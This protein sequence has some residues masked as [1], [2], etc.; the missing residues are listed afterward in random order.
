MKISRRGVLLG[1]AAA[2]ALIA[3]NSADAWFKS[4]YAMGWQTI[5]LG[6]GGLMPGIDVADDGFLVCRSDVGNAYQFPGTVADLFTSTVRWQPLLSAESL[7]GITTTPQCGGSA[8]MFELVQA[9]GNSDY[10]YAIFD[11]PNASALQGVFT[12]TNRGNRWRQLTGISNLANMDSNGTWRQITRRIAVDPNQPLLAYIGMCPSS[13]QSSSL[14]RTI[15]GSSVSVVTTDGVT[16]FPQTTV[17]PGC[18]GI[19]FDRNY[20]GGSGGT[21]ITVGGQVRTKRVIAPVGGVDMYETLDG[22]QTWASTGLAAALTT[23]YGRS[24]FGI[25]CAS[26]NYDGTYFAW[27]FFG[28]NGGVAPYGSVWRYSGASGIWALAY[29]GTSSFGATSF[30]VV[31]ADPRLGQEGYLCLMGP[32]DG[33]TSSNANASLGSTSP[34]ITWNGP[35]S[36]IS[37]EHIQGPTQDAQWFSDYQGS[38]LSPSYGVIDNNGVCYWTGNRGVFVNT[39][40]DF[41]T[42]SRPDFNSGGLDTYSVSMVRGME[43]TVC[44]SICKPPGG[45]Y[46]ITG[47]QDVSVHRGT[48]IGYPQ[49]FWPGLSSTGP[50]TRRAHCECVDF[51][52]ADPSFVVCKSTVSQGNY[53]YSAFNTNYGADGF[54][55]PFTNLPDNE[56][57]ASSSSASISGN[58]LTVGGTITG[59]WLPNQAVTVGGISKGTVASQLTGTPWG[60]GTYQLSS[61]PGDTTGAATGT[62]LATLCGQILAIDKDHIL[63][64]PSGY[65]TKLVPIVT[66]NAQSSCTWT[67]CN[68]LP[69]HTWA[70]RSWVFGPMSRPLDADYVAL[71][72]VYAMAHGYPSAG[73]STIYRSTDYGQNWSS[74]GTLTFSDTAHGPMVFVDKNQSG[75]VY[76]TAYSSQS[77]QQIYKCFNATSGSPTFSEVAAYPTAPY[78]VVMNFCLGAPQTLGGNAT[79]FMQ[80]WPN[81]TNRYANY[82]SVKMF[83]SDNDGASWTELAQ[84]SP[85]K[86]GNLYSYS[87]LGPGSIMGD[88]EVYGKIY[89]C[90]RSVGPSF[91]QP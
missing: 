45:P 27:V 73:T 28:G 54:W 42:P 51:G 31:I 34:V 55:T 52:R 56:Y 7:S 5:P 8:G 38:A 48:W 23:A 11:Q 32:A 4:G 20:T 61:S 16:A 37:H 57:I 89:A 74:I 91:Y 40:A 41:T 36:G 25:S 59:L 43:S 67:A 69:L 84:S 46:P 44:E 83:K 24:D 18:A 14:Y 47:C 15:D 64:I 49:H 68:G 88:W 81:Y 35:G 10:L 50:L 60:A 1:S 71:G 63:V 9:P 22:G 33:Y 39:L 75:H 77:T 58:V 79:L 12:S 26:I 17:Q 53:D 86:M 76:F 82:P 6:C 70:N 21:T 65:N 62:G 80:G 66:T 85:D 30:A 13:G 2:G 78:N 87:T 29:Q 19:V 3:V 72:T 90:W